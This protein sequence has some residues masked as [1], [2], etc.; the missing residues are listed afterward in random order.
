MKS[1]ASAATAAL[2]RNDRTAHSRAIVE[3]A[4]VEIR[5]W[6][7]YRNRLRRAAR[8]KRAG[9][10][11][12]G[13][14]RALLLQGAGIE[15]RRRGKRRSARDGRRG[16]RKTVHVDE[17]NLRTD[18]NVGDGRRVAAAGAVGRLRRCV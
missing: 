7:I 17:V 3:E 14:C 12:A 10:P 9:A 11:V 15:R 16:M 13:D 8:L 5:A 18:G 1:A 2:L 6:P 4:P